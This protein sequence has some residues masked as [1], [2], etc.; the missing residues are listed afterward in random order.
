MYIKHQDNP[1]IPKTESNFSKLFLRFFFSIF[2]TVMITALSLQYGFNSLIQVF[3]KDAINTYYQDLVRGSFHI[4]EKDI[5]QQPEAFWPEYMESLQ[6]FFG[7]PISIHTAESLHLTPQERE[8]LL[9]G[10]ILVQEK[11]ELYHKKIENSTAILTM[12][13]FQEPN[14]FIPLNILVWIAFILGFGSMT[15]IWTYPYARKLKKINHAV[16][17]FGAGDLGSRVRIPKTSSLA[18]M[19]M[20]FNAMADKITRLIASHRELIHAI[21]HEL[22]TPAARIRFGLEILRTAERDTDRRRYTDGMQGDVDEM[23]RLLS[24]LLTYTRL[25]GTTPALQMQE[26]EPGPWLIKILKDFKT[27]HPDITLDWKLEQKGTTSFEPFYMARAVKNLLEN[28]VRYGRNAIFVH[29]LFEKGVCCIHVDDNGSG[30]A[31][32]DRGKIFEPF[33]RLDPSRSRETG[34]HG[35]G[36][37]IVFNIMASH[38]GKVCIETASMGGAR[39]SL[40][41]PSS[42]KS[43]SPA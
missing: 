32:E 35:L 43:S 31:P 18:P 4:M 25:N 7:Y 30:I 34:G 26:G 37:A 22:R 33:V 6:P 29:L 17:A 39:F 36:L 23:E 1:D 8:E 12:G 2:V 14:I 40:C 20:A 41:W 9:A 10:R 24:E 3:M 16:L 5:L 27:M 13:K 11:G 42:K 28:A 21:S 19:A 38:G 15:L